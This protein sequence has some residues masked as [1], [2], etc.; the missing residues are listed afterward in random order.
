MPRQPTPQQEQAVEEAFF[1]YL[2]FHTRCAG[3]TAELLQHEMALRKTSKEYHCRNC[4]GAADLVFLPSGDATLTRRAAK[5]SR[6]M[7]PVVEWNKRRKRFERRGTLVQ[8]AALA[9]AQASCAMD[10]DKRAVTREK[11]R[12][13]AA[14]E[15]QKYVEEFA[16]K[17]NEMFPG[18]DEKTAQRIARHACEKYSG[19][20][21]RTAG[22]KQLDPELVTVAVV[23]HARHEHTNYDHLRAIGMNKEDSRRRIRPTIDRLL[24]KWRHP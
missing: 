4:A 23:A 20:V 24:E 5:F 21:G 19:R 22:A 6:L 1:V 7:F 10:E 13:R 17:V 15:D 16:R 8:E 18:L 3:C 11:A 12:E 2:D 9:E 14:V